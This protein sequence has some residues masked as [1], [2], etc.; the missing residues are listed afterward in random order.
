MPDKTFQ[1][2]AAI[3]YF[4][5]WVT[6]AV[7]TTIL[8][9][10][11]RDPEFRIRWHAKISLV[12]IITI[13]FFMFLISPS[14]VSLFFIGIPGGLIGYLSITKTTICKSCGKIIQPVRLFNRAQFCP[15]C[16]GETVCSKIFNTTADQK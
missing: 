11:R 13:L 8:F 2:V 4:V 3:V 16:G 12:A 14:W 1:S 15:Y 6:L 7:G 10:V 9:W 5:V